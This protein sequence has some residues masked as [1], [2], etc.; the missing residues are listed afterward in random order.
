MEIVTCPTCKMRVIPKSDGTCP[1]CLSVLEEK[2]QPEA[3]LKEAAPVKASQ[4]EVSSAPSEQNRAADLYCPDCGGVV[5][6]GDSLCP[7]CGAA[8]DEF[9]AQEEVTEGKKRHWCL[10]A[11]LVLILIAS[12]IAALIYLLRGDVILSRLTAAAPVWYL[13]ALAVFLALDL[14]GAYAVF[15]WQKWGFWLFCGTSAVSFVLTLAVGG[16]WVLALPGVVGALLL[17][18]AL[19]VGDENKGWPQLE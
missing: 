15:Q 14:A 5:S 4:V 7:H 17:Y 13:P 12:I 19:N 8:L 3:V 16:G 2:P 6:E 10:T 9:V 11:W 1:S 18:G